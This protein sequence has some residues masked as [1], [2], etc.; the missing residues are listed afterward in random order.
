MEGGHTRTRHG[1]NADEKRESWD[2][3]SME[4]WKCT[5]VGDRCRSGGITVDRC[6]SEWDKED[7]GSSR[8]NGGD[9]RQQPE[10]EARHHSGEEWRDDGA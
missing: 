1:G 7:R 2:V 8:Q 3:R 9:T 5:T 4:P 6:R 10:R